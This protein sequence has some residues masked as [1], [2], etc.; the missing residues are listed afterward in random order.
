MIYFKFL[1][2]LLKHKYY[3]FKVGLKLKVPIH[4]LILH[5]WQKFTPKEFGVYARNFCGDYTNSPVDREIIKGEFA[6]AW[7]H[8]ENS[9]DHH[10]GY[11]VPRSGKNINKPLEM[12]EV[13]VREMVADWYG[14][15]MAYTG[16]YEVM[17]WFNT[18]NMNLHKNTYNLT[19]R[20][21]KESGLE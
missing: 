7:L 14:A 16:E 10:W 5:D 4:R 8:H 6:Y 17:E 21:I 1:K 15:S 20:I 3:V 18:G 2:Q 19:F 12:P 11:W 9:A 13:C